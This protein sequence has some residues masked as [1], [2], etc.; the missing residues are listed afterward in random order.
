MINAA[1]GGMHV[2]LNHARDTGLGQAALKTTTA[3]VLQ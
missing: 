2:P 3:S 1:F